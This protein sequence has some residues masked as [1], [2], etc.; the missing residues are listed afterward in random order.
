M[1]CITKTTL[2]FNPIVILGLLII[3]VSTNAQIIPDN[4][5]PGS[6]SITMPANINGSPST[7]IE[8]G[9]SIGRN[10]LHSFREFNIIQGRGAYFINPSGI[11]AIL[12]RVTGV[13]PSFIDGKLGVLGNADLFFLN[14]N[15]I[16][17][18]GNSSLDLNGSFL[19]STARDI[20]F[21]DGSRFGT[22]E[23]LETPS[24]NAEI[25]GLYINKTSKDIGFKGEG[26]NL[27]TPDNGIAPLLESNNQ[28]GLRVKQSNT[29]GLIANNLN[30]DGAT[31][32]SE[33][34][35]IDIAAV[36]DGIINLKQNRSTWLFNYKDIKSFGNIS[37]N[38]KTLID[39]RGV[40]SNY[41]SVTGKD[42]FIRDGSVIYFEN[43][44]SLTQADDKLIN[45]L[46]VQATNTIIIQEVSPS[47]DPISSGIY[48]TTFGSS[49]GPDIFL[50]ALTLKVL[51]G[52]IVAAGSF[53]E[54]PGGNINISTTDNAYLDSN[55]TINPA[56]KSLITSNAFSSGKGGDIKINSKNLVISNGGTISSTTV[57]IGNAGSIDVEAQEEVNIF[58]IT[59]I[60]FP[61]TITNPRNSTLISSTVGFGTGGDLNIKA[62]SLWVSDGASIGTSTSSF[63][64]AGNIFV[65]ADFIK[66]SGVAPSIVFASVL[67]SFSLNEGNSGNLDIKTK[68]LAVTDGAAVGVV[69]TAAGNAGLLNIEATDSI[70]VSGRFNNFLPSSIGSGAIVSDPRT[71]DFLNLPDIPSGQVAGLTLKTPLLTIKNGGRISVQNDGINDA[72]TLKISADKF[73]IDN[74]FLLATASGNGGDIS[75][76][77]N[78]LS[79]NNGRISSSSMGQGIGGNVSINSDLVVAFGKSSISA[80][81]QNAQG[82]RITFNTIGFF[83]SPDTSI[84]ATSALGPQLS[85]SVTFS[86]PDTDLEL[87]TTTVETEVSQ[88]EV[89]SICRPTSNSFSEFIV[90]GE[91]GLPSGPGDALSE[92]TGWHDAVGGSE[93]A[94]TDNAQ[95]PD[96]VDAQGWVKNSDGTF[97]LVAS[98]S[99]PITT[100][101][102]STP[103]NAQVQNSDS[104]LSDSSASLRADALSTRSH[105][106]PANPS[107]ALASR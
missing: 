56:S 36:E 94:N 104:T 79:L 91:G 98:T 57:G 28:N 50:S 71:R 40:G 34:G 1:N 16:F 49:K 46:S 105:S 93:Q 66:V 103:C 41:I 23:L 21:S 6:P 8:G 10:Q 4:S 13:V 76:K 72:G 39:S 12:V 44:S 58:G 5:L 55:S 42:V 29:I 68:K 97:S 30:F 90:S 3:P 62:N 99:L 52:G 64:N 59:S 86:N 11:N 65:D 63:G 53:S 51:D 17:F 82:G 75:L 87:A 67:S 9:I 38:N 80:N 85:G 43:N 22:S 106:T 54:G 78:L 48:S 19:G 101:E 15:G 26:H 102:T 69:S 31:V 83:P 81:A 88:P 18:G 96:L 74:A 37:F 77:T 70:S 24:S 7:R 73:I 107:P 25:T 32:A 14:P 84:T 27:F 61:M 20:L 89:S 2:R 95:V 33:S 100:A 45:R 92:N 60:D 47:R 35:N